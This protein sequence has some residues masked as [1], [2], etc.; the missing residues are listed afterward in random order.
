VSCMFG[1]SDMF[2]KLYFSQSYPRLLLMLFF[3]F[4]M[5][6]VVVGPEITFLEGL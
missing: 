2:Y 1:N 4:D 3:G 5:F 6:V